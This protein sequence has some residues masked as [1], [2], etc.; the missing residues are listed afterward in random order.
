MMAN[1]TPDLDVEVHDVIPGRVVPKDAPKAPD[2]ISGSVGYGPTNGVERIV[3]L[4]GLRVLRDGNFVNANE[5]RD[6]DGSAPTDAD[7]T[8]P[9]DEGQSA[10]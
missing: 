7:V 3:D 1:Y 2:E 9:T 6:N 8:N 5:L 10:T 4:R